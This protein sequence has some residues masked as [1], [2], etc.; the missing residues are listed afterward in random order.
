MSAKVLP[1]R[2]ERAESEI[3]QLALYLAHANGESWMQVSSPRW[4]QI[5]NIARLAL[6]AMK[7]GDRG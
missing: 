7:G 4:A 3:T 5:E 2:A 1:M 6:S